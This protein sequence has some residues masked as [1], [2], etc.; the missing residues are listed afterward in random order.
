M[1]L[2]KTGDYIAMFDCI[3][4]TAHLTISP[5]ELPNVLKWSVQYNMYS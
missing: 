5:S 1:W 4:N 3:W 2:L